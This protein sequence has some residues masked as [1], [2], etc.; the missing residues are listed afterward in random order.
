MGSSCEGDVLIIFS[1]LGF[2]VISFDRPPQLYAVGLVVYALHGL[3]LLSSFVI[4][5]R[6][7]DLIIHCTNIV[8]SLRRSSR[9]SIVAKISARTCCV[10]SLVL[11]WVY[12]EKQPSIVSLGTT[13][14]LSGNQ[15]ED[16]GSSACVLSLAYIGSRQHS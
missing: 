14:R 7:G 4:Q 13:S 5:G 3:P 2:T 6:F 12:D 8:D 9:S 10:Y 16:E 15:L 1:L 11:Q